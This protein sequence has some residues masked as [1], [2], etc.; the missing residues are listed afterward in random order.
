VSYQRIGQERTLKIG[1]NRKLV[2]CVLRIPVKKCIY[3]ELFC[4]VAEIFIMA[5]ID[6]LKE[7]P[8]FQLKFK[9]GAVSYIDKDSTVWN[10]LPWN[11]KV[12][13][14]SRW[15]NPFTS[16][17]GHAPASPC[18]KLADVI[19][20]VNGLEILDL[21]DQ[22]VIGKLYITSG[23]CVGCAAFASRSIFSQVDIRQKNLFLSSDTCKSAKEL[24]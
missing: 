6:L 17:I 23:A 9:I 18:E 21:A 16:V 10:S 22:L 1:F 2:L 14:S 20:H 11:V 3:I 24:Q 8:V 7:W 19:A 15:A 12:F 5:S 13:L 4:F